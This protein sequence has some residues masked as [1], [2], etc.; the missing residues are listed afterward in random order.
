VFGNI[1]AIKRIEI[2]S[3]EGRRT[4]MQMAFVGLVSLYCS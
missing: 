4:G 3:K 2:K 1:L